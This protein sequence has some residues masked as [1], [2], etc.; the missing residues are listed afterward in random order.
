MNR[1]S[2]TLTDISYKK[3]FLKAF[4]A[5]LIVLLLIFFLRNVFENGFI[6]ND[7]YYDDYRYE[8]GGEYYAQNAKAIIDVDTFKNAYASV[9]DWVGYHLKTGVWNSTPAWYWIVCIIMYLTKTKWAVRLLNIVLSSIAVIYVHKFT[10]IVYGKKT[11][12]MASNLLTFLPYPLI[13]SCFAYKDQLIMLC[14]FYLLYVAVRFRYHSAMNVKTIIC[15]IMVSVLLMLTRGGFT[16]LLLVLCAAIALIK[17]IKVRVNIRQFIVIAFVVIAVIF[18]FA[19]SYN[20]IIYK[21]QYYNTRHEETLTGTNVAFIT[22]NS[23]W[24]IYKLPLTYIFSLIMPIQMFNG[25]SSWYGIVANLNVCMTP[26][27]MGAFFYIFRSN[28][29]DKLVYWGSLILYLISI[30]TSINIFRHYYSLMPLTLIAF[31]NEWQLSGKKMKGLIFGFG[32]LFAI[33]VVIY[34][35]IK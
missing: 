30:V 1:D 4:V 11:A 7:V 9:G 34:Y 6:A 2:K 8:V 24:Q 5:R 15:S 25:I 29:P 3:V 32:I 19:K 18:A 31:S 28:K 14:T 33:V 20:T 22:I 27:A 13:F 10:K 17:N 16:A 12:D 23:I 26:I 35:G 21:L